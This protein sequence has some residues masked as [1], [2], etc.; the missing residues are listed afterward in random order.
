MAST[1]SQGRWN[2]G[3]WNNSADGAIVTG[4]SL[5]SSLTNVTISEGTGIQVAATGSSVAS[6]VSFGFGWSR[7]SYNAGKWNTSIGNIIAGTGSIF[8]IT[9]EEL[10]SS[11]GSV[12]LTAGSIA[13]ITGE[14]LTITV[15]NVTTS[16]SN[17]I[18]I[19]GQALTGAISN[20]TIVGGAYFTVTGSQANTAVGSVTTGS[21]AHISTTG[22]ALASNLSSITITTGQN[23]SI[24]GPA[25]GT[26]VAI[27]QGTKAIVYSDGTTMVDVGKDLG[28]INVKGIGNQA[29]SNYFIWP[30]ADGSNGQA[31][32]TDGSKTLSFGNVAASGGISWQTVITADPANA[33]VNYG[34]FCNTAAGAFTVTLPVTGTIG[35]EIAF[36]DYAG[37][38]VA[39][40]LTIDKNGHK[41]QGASANLTIST[42]RAAF[43]LVYVDATEG[44]LLKNK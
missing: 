19:T 2:F 28:N 7:A 40:N 12:T 8:S 10:T 17:L 21:A 29:S 24:T 4:N 15:N 36:I 20:V 42:E 27:D 33:V 14:D 44:W 43:S 9:G 38:F 35:D 1:W 39:N 25:S 3:S 23:I 30:D 6:D 31:L 13:T 22:Q 11:L 37:D 34:Y 18:D 26:G 16:G 5:T 32:I 41:I